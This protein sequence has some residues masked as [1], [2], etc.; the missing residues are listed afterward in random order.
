MKICGCASCE[1]NGEVN[2]YDEFE[3]WLSNRDDEFEKIFK[4]SYTIGEMSDLYNELDSKF[5]NGDVVNRINSH[6]PFD[7]YKYWMGISI[8]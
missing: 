2:P 4:H 5:N 6:A 1:N 8:E 3:K 7:A